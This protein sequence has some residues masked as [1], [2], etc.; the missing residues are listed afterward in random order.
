MPEKATVGI[1]GPNEAIKYNENV[2]MERTRFA[3][4]NK[5]HIKVK[6]ETFRL[7]LG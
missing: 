4:D 6:I 1:C 5:G 3:R 2:Q 7:R